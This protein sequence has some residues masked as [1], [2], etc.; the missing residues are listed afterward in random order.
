MT[1][2]TILK[3]VVTVTLAAFAIRVP[4]VASEKKESACT[5]PPELIPGP[6][7]SKE[8]EKK[9][10]ELRAQGTVAISIS[11]EGDVVDASVVRSS[12]REA[13]DALL[14]RAKSMKFKPRPGCGIFKTAVNYTLAGQ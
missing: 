7:P 14:A 9:A 13:A 4:S 1:K 10:R 11:E 2:R 3:V 12:S 5:K 6:K 8:E